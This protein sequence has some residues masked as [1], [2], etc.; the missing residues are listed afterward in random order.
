MP[1]EALREDVRKLREQLSSGQPLT[2]EQR[3][4]LD[5]T[6]DQIEPLLDAGSSDVDDNET[7]AGRLRELASHLEETHLDLTLAVGRVA[8]A[9]SRLGI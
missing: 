6:L 9:L 5:Q 4:S 3:Q 7:V 8:D 1:R 2:S